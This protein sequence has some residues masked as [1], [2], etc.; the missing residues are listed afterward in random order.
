MK[1]AKWIVSSH[2]RI[3]ELFKPVRHR[4]DCAA[5]APTALC[6]FAVPKR[7]R[8]GRF[9]TGNDRARASLEGS[10][11]AGNATRQ[12]ALPDH[13]QPVDRHGPLALAQGTARSAGGRSGTTRHGSAR[14]D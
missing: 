9:G 6:A 3:N 13:A 2:M 12:L 5:A 4:A 11:A 8:R 10:M 1:R 7:D 14:G